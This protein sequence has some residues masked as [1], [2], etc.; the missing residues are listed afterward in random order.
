MGPVGILPV[1][2]Q[3]NVSSHL[4]PSRSHEVAGALTRMQSLS[5]NGAG[6]LQLSDVVGE[7]HQLIVCMPHSVVMS[8]WNIWNVVFFV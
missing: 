3:S 2:L 7:L 1:H 4:D 5:S 8:I 6:E